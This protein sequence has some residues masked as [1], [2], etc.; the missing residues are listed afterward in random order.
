MIINHFQTTQMRSLKACKGKLIPGLVK[1]IKGDSLFLLHNFYRYKKRSFFSLK[2]RYPN[3]RKEKKAFIYLF[4]SRAWIRRDEKASKILS[5]YQQK[6]G[7]KKTFCKLQTT[8]ISSKNV[9]SMWRDGMPLK[10]VDD[11]TKKNEKK[12]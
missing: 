5:K 6:E 8:C 4:V 9:S 12:K 10:R 11:I 2:K 7:K 3:T 1:D